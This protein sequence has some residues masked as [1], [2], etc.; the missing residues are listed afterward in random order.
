[1]SNPAISQP[2]TL[3]ISKTGGTQPYFGLSCGNKI[4]SRMLS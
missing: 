4:T 2:A 1:M 3:E